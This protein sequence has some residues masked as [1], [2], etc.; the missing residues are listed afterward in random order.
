MMTSNP[1]FQPTSNPF[2]PY[3]PLPLLYILLQGWNTLGR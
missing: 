2:Q 1:A 3:Q